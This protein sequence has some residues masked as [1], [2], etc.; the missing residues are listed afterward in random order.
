MFIQKSKEQE[1]C[2]L[3]MV[4]TSWNLA[5]FLIKYIGCTYDSEVIEK[6]KTILTVVAPL[7]TTVLVSS[8]ELKP[9][10]SG[11]KNFFWI[12]SSSDCVYMKS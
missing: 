4:P 3:E 1:L 7:I 10:F 8:L 2:K 12:L 5:A 9:H 6:W 11:P